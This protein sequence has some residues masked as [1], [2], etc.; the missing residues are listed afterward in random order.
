MDVG[1]LEPE[2]ADAD[3]GA[4]ELQ[5][6]F[7]VLQRVFRP[8]RGK[9]KGGKPGLRDPWRACACGRRQGFGK[10]CLPGAAFEVQ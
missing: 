9:G 1:A 8:G 2:P 4:R 5:A 6:A 3:H 7:A 10:R